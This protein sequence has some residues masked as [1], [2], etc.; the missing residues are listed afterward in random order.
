MKDLSDYATRMAA[1]TSEAVALLAKVASEIGREVAEEGHESGARHALLELR[2]W[3]DAGA[4][5]LA[6]A[7]ARCHAIADKI[8]ALVAQQE[9]KNHADD[10]I[11]A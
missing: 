7:G 8:A 4:S 3:C 11:T 1:A 10:E 6:V 5:E 2:V 9:R